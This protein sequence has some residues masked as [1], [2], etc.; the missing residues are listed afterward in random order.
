M[1][2]RRISLA[3]VLA[4]SA[5]LGGCA[6]IRALFAEGQSVCSVI[7]SKE[8]GYKRVCQSGDFFRVTA[9][10]RGEALSEAEQASHTHLVTALAPG[11]VLGTFRIDPSAEGGLRAQP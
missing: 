10:S 11:R 7:V 9:I 8:E 4:L 6:D 5:G 1:S 2:L 3:G